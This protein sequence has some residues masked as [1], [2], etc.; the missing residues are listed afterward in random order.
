L[1]MSSSRRSPSP[2]RGYRDERSHGRPRDEGSYDRPLDR[3]S[4]AYRQTRDRGFDRD[5]RL[6]DGRQNRDRERDGPARQNERD[7]RDRPSE[8]DSRQREDNDRRAPARRSASPSRARR[9]RSRSRSQSPR[10]DKAKP[11][12]ANSG[13]L[14]AETKTV[15]SADGTKTV[16]KYHEPPEARKPLVSWR[17]YVFKGQEQ[18]GE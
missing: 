13:L 11:N 2:R 6:G 4:D 1:T 15:Q 5:A 14:A 12:F 17:L 8:R 3:R 10:E 9:S 7:A 18:V 16:L